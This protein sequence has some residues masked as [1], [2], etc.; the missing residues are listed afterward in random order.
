MAHGSLTGETLT[1]TL[2]KGLRNGPMEAAIGSSELTATAIQRPS[3][4]EAVGPYCRGGGR[5]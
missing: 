1:E 3:T 5:V 2:L 4:T